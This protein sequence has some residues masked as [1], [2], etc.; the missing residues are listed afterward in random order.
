M[1]DNDITKGD[2]CLFSGI[3]KT[4]SH[5]NELVDAIEQHSKVL[6]FFHMS[7]P[8]M[9]GAELLSKMTFPVTQSATSTES[10]PS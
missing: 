7:T 6:L 9:G 8:R 1:K 10:P 3:K 2:I 5:E 4:S